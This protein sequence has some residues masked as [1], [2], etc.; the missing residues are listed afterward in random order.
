MLSG[1]DCVVLDIHPGLNAP[2]NAPAVCMLDGKIYCI[3]G[4]DI[5]SGKTLDSTECCM[6]GDGWKRL[7]AA[8]PCPRFGASAFSVSAAVLTG[9]IAETVCAS[10]GSF[11][12]ACLCSGWL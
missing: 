7:Q 5:A 4:M 12:K 11:E 9:L 6:P 8:M 1:T 2:R 10:P 3:G